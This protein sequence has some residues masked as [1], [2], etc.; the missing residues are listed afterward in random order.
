[1][2]TCTKC[3]TEKAFSEFYTDQRV[4]SGTTSWCKECSKQWSREQVLNG[5]SKRFAFHQK[6]RR[7]NLSEDRYDEMVLLQE[8]QC[9]IC[10]TEDPG[11][12]K[13]GDGTTAFGVD[14][15]H[16][17]CPGRRSCG[18]CV[19]SLLCVKCNNG[20]GCFSDNTEV[21]DNAIEYLKRW[22]KSRERIDS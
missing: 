2:K 5:D 16:A 11:F 14:H 8:N 6:L 1:M 9:A 15:D 13:G 12:K 17:C 22:T 21:M 18:K 10:K 3:L 20:L 7:F 4:K 19:R